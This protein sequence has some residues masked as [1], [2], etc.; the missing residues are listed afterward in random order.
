MYLRRNLES[1]RITGRATHDVR[2]FTICR[3]H[4]VRELWS[5]DRGF[6]RFAGVRVIN[7]LIA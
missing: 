4:V 5:A 1:G 2:I 7:P 3:L 6:T